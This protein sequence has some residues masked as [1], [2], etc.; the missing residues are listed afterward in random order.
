MKQTYVRVK[1]NGKS[2]SPK[3]FVFKADF[4]PKEGEQIA[5]RTVS[6]IVVDSILSEEETHNFL[7]RSNK[8]DT[9]IPVVIFE[10][11]QRNCMEVK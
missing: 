4:E 3:Y 6:P 2:R 8:K 10:E 9:D 5:M 1:S 7:K 11:D